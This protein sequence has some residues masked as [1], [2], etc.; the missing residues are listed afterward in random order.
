MMNKKAI[1]AVATVLAAV[2]A[3]SKSG[4]S[5]NETQ[6]PAPTP[7][8][9]EGQVYS[10]TGTISAIA[11]DQVSIAHGPI[12]GIGWPAMTMT[13]TAPSEVAAGVRVGDQVDFGFRKN[14]SS[15]LLT[16][17]QKR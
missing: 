14:G 1:F 17:L 5:T 12:S 9:Q 15:Y 2:S 4:P 16:A 3:C 7:A 11:G 6:T 8:D 10:G 13:F